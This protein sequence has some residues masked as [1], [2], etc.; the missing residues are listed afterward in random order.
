M[1]HRHAGK[2]VTIE[3]LKEFQE[4]NR[5]MVVYHHQTRRK[6]GHLLEISDLTKRLRKNGLQVSG[7]LRAEPW[8][9]RV[10][11]IFNGDKELHNRAENM[12]KVWGNLI[13]WYSDFR[14]PIW[15]G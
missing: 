8:S 15:P 1:T 7:A 12:T 2:S 11:F 5:S 13:S 6:G 10:F 14:G 9:P 4:S 3:E